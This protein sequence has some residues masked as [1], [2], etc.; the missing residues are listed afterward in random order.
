MIPTQRRSG[1]RFAPWVSLLALLSFVPV[2]AAN[3][4]NDNKA[5]TEQPLPNLRFDPSALPADV[6]ARTSFA[7]IAKKVAPSVVNVYSTRTVR[8]SAPLL[9]DP[10]FRR[11][12][13][14]GENPAKPRTERGLGSGVIIS[15]DGYI[16]TNNHVVEDS[17][18]IRVALVSG[19][20]YP[21]KVVGADPATD[22][23]VIK[24]DAHNLP[25]I[26][27]TDSSKIQVGDTVLAVGNPFGVGQT[28]TMGIVS[29]TGRSGFGIVNYED[30]IQTDAS[31][32]PGNSGGALTDML[33]RLIG[34]NTAILSR[35]GG[36]QGVGFA[37]PSNMARYV[38]Q[39]IIEHGKVVR[40]YLGIQIQSLSPEL[41]KAFK[42]PAR[43]GALVANVTPRSP[44]AQAGL[45]E[46][47]VITEF[48]GKKVTDSRHLQ[49][50][51]AQTPPE[52]KAG[53][54]VLRNGKEQEIN[55][56]LGEMPAEELAQGRGEPETRSGR[57]GSLEGMQVAELDRQTRRQ[58]NIPSN[59]DGLVITEVEPGSAA[60]RAGLQSGDVI[61]EIDRHVVHSLRDMNRLR[62]DA[63]QGTV[64]LRVWSNGASH[65]VALETGTPK[66]KEAPGN[67]G[68]KTQPE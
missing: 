51:V 6:Q 1:L 8:E 16:L 30:F 40:G 3:Q 38:M 15:D 31:I 32:N 59:V 53:L 28:V 47:D 27:M 50:M 52:T 26:T 14:E 61:E 29:A 54:Q 49:L 36:N 66:T 12:F 65:Y 55:V 21:A 60:E 19:E 5:E 33:G 24:V 11:F 45:K 63:T 2:R 7:P 56:T 13:G 17:T 46:G 62:N 20:E 39:Q 35:S 42:V 34:L 10:F 4:A 57:A 18:D 48:N 68:S 9:G 43:E 22:V 64:L 23:A 67:G 41:A 58:L 25:A 44:A 37:V